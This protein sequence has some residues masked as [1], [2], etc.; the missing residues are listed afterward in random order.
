MISRKMGHT[1]FGICREHEG[2]PYDVYLAL[3]GDNIIGGIGVI[4]ND[5]MSVPI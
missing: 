3:E 4:E 1:A 5:F 2:M